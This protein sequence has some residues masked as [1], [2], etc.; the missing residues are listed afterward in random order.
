MGKPQHPEMVEQL[1]HE[2]LECDDVIRA[3]FLAKACAGDVTLL[4]EVTS[5]LASYE[6]DRNFLQKSAF[7][8]SALNVAGAVLKETGMPEVPHVKG[9]NLIREIGRG[10]MGAVYEAFST[11]GE[12]GRRVAVKLIKRGM[13]TEFVL[14]RF[15]RERRILRALNH[16]Y[17]ARF[18]DG[19]TTD[20]GLP[21]FI[22]EYVEGLP[23][24]RYVKDMTLPTTER[25]LL[26]LKVCEAVSYAHRHRIIHAGLKP[27]NILVTE[28]GVP[29]LLDFGVAKLLDLD[30]VGRTA[31]VT[32]TSMAHR[33][34]TPE[35]ASP[36][37]LR[38]LPPKETDAVYSL[39]LLFYILLT[40]DHPYRFCNRA[41]VE[42]LRSIIEG[43]VR[44]PSEAVGYSPTSADETTDTTVRSR[45]GN[46]EARRD[47]RGNLDN[48]ALKALHKEPERRYASVEEMAE[49]IRRHLA[50]RPV[51]ARPDSLAY[52][53]ARFAGRHP[54][55]TI[56]TAAVALLCLL[57]G[58]IVGLSS[59]PATP[60]T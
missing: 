33:V 20:D 47:L 7:N 6:R 57:L 34:M 50:G 58:L 8:L 27:S 38:G 26:F 28:A 59:K 55:Y 42:I 15:D 29:K 35:Y 56:S 48:I 49:D 52:R 43:R 24:D 36:S 37:Q 39:G 1:F 51:S 30:S 21:F 25:L 54:T 11:D 41:P 17:I 60:R 31:D 18:L 53:A 10:G 44:R 22:M 40:G 5:L 13:D 23:I 2:A 12:M 19:G 46:N 16:T 32:T 9:F 3:S 45:P 14:R 4:A